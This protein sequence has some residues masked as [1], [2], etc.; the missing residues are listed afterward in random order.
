MNSDHPHMA[1]LIWGYFGEDFDIYGH[2]VPEIISKYLEVA[3]ISRK[4]RLIYEIGRFVNTNKD[5]RY[6]RPHLNARKIL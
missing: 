3:P 6:K 4:I 1:Q 2:T 5:D